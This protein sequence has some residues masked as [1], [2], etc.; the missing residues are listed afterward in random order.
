M[1]VNI[2][3]MISIKKKEISLKK[4]EIKIEKTFPGVNN[5]VCRARVPQTGE[6]EE[7]DIRLDVLEPPS[8]IQLVINHGSL[9]Q[10]FISMTIFRH[11]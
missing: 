4:K 3:V 9:W 7:R 11:L 10:Y 1:Q 5:F 8:W 6:L 2:G